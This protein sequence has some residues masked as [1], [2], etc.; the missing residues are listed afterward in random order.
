MIEWLEEDAAAG[1][2]NQYYDL[3]LAARFARERV[4]IVDV[5]GTKWFE[6]DTSDDLDVAWKL[7][8]GSA[9]RGRGGDGGSL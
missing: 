6:I 1:S 4:A 2:T 5:A 9:A 7:F 8:G 3:T